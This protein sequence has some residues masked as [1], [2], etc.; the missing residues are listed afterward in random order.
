[1]KDY[2]VKPGTDATI[3]FW[4][5]T[6]V[7]QYETLSA[8]TAGEFLDRIN[9]PTKWLYGSELRDNFLL[10]DTNNFCRFGHLAR[11][12]FIY[13]G[14]ENYNPHTISIRSEL[15]MR[16][17]IRDTSEY[18]VQ[19]KAKDYD[20]ELID[21]FLMRVVYDELGLELPLDYKAID[22]EVLPKFRSIFHGLDFEP[23][24]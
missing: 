22:R 4:E 11:K 18:K 9:D 10:H 15:F 21:N 1:M 16:L 8:E 13:Y 5:L 20:W 2:E 7:P 3:K 14:G 23:L 24:Q 19:G 6:G 12:A 17:L